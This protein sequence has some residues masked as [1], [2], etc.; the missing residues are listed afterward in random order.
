MKADY[1][2]YKRAANVSLIGLLIQGLLALLLFVYAYY[3]SDH[4]AMTAALFVGLGLPVWLSLMILFDQQRRERIEAIEAEAMAASGVGVSSA[5]DEAGEDARPA[6]QRLRNL[7][8]FVLPSIALTLAAAHAGSGIW[9]LGGAADLLEQS[10]RLEPQHRGWVISIGLGLAFVGF[11]F[12][13]FVSGMARQD[14]W[15]HLR[16]GAA[17][18][19]GAALLGLLLVVA[20][21]TDIAGPSVLVHWLP[22]VM[23]WF[24]IVIAAEIV[25]VFLFDLYRPRKKGEVPALTFESRLLGLVAAS[26]RVVES[27]GEALNYQ[28]G[29]DISSTWFYTLVRRITPILIVVVIL[30]VWGLS[31]FTV[32]Y[33]HQRGLLVRNGTLVRELGP[34]LHVTLPWPFDRVDIPEHR[35]PEPN[36]ADRM[37]VT[38]TATGVR[39][40]DLAGP[41]ISDNILAVLWS[42]Q[43]APEEY[44]FICQPTRVGTSDAAERSS[45]AESRGELALVAAQITMH[46]T[47]SDVE[48][49]DRLAPPEF[50]DDLLRSVA[51][52]AITKY[53]GSRALDDIISDDRAAISE[54]LQTRVIEALD[55]LNPD[56]DG[57]P[58]GAGVEVR[59]VGIETAHPP[60]Q[61]APVFERVVQAEQARLAL[62]AAADADRI[63][64][65]SEVVGSVELAERSAVELEALYSL[66]DSGGSD[67][68]VAEQALEV[69]AL[70][71]EAGGDADAIIQAARADRWNRHMGERGRAARHVGRVA[72]YRAA[73][74]LY[75]TQEYLD[76]LAEV[77]RAARVYLVPSDIPLLPDIDLKDNDTQAE[78]FAPDSDEDF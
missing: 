78:I 8:K 49:F 31:C 3:A 21:F 69:E 18:S 66:R 38:E 75:R 15:S 63:A 77:M 56:S 70:L 52:R 24:S 39:S 7:T 4:A 57:V 64:T 62:I 1:L 27:I 19:V 36:D 12:A 71:S 58:Q 48:V 22:A 35:V 5:F 25:L 14:V 6:A 23:P 13:R 67:T 76:K 9:R 59:F 10:D 45:G 16:A 34:G 29:V 54:E 65:L 74:T 72:A 17:Y 43:H 26:D 73:P 44:Y 53:L 2:A 55:A 20:H 68:E 50:R 46:Y 42:E 30:V 51:Q 40:L 11:V 33:P 37:I 32:L 47:V 60:Q 61:V 41:Q 28:F